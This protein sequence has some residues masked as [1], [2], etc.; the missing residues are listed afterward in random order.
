MA[1]E[2]RGGG[3][4]RPGGP[5]PSQTTQTGKPGLHEAEAEKVKQQHGQKISSQDAQRIA[6]QAGYQKAQKKQG[7]K[8]DVGDSSHSPIPIPDDEDDT[9][10][11]SPELLEDA[12]G[13]L[14]LASA[15]FAEVA[16]GA[17]EAE[18][19]DLAQSIVGGSHL[20]TEE[21]LKKLQDLADRKAPEPIPLD[22][23]T[24]NVKQLFNIEL[25]ED[26]PVGHKLLAAGLVVGGEAGSVAV[27][28][29]KLDEKRLAGGLQKVADRSNQAVGEAQK[30]SK[31]V[32]RELNLQR[33]FVF[34]R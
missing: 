21:G 15:Q 7:K 33:T 24:T 9:D 16:K 26:V 8:F 18:G 23:V 31:G 29:G 6:Q 27:E 20:P 1:N 17:Q 14:A 32:S 25:G 28:E 5:L 30:M 34:K 22:E 13:N 10:V 3:P 2:I 12:Q 19:A 4:M 11:W